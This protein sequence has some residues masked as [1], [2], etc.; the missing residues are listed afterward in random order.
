MRTN[1]LWYA[2]AIWL[3]VGGWMAAAPILAA[4]WQDL[5][6]ANVSQFEAGK[7]IAITDKGVAFFTDMK[8]DRDVTCQSKP[9][10]DLTI[11]KR[12]FDIEAQGDG[13]SW[14]LLSVTKDAKAGSYSV[15]CTMDDRGADTANY[16][17][18]ELPSFSAAI[19]NG[20]GIGILATTAAA[21][22]AGWTYWGRRTQRKLLSYESS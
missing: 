1:P 10:E 18:A 9:T 17:Y 3:V 15:S 16:A 19:R 7:K 5:K 20:R 4:P 22:I 14:H 6:S 8:Q 13:R 21:L 12:P 2:A 11:E